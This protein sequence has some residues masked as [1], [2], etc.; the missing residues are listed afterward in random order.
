MHAVQSVFPYTTISNL[1]RVTNN[2]G[3]E[4]VRSS[5]RTL[6]SLGGEHPSVIPSLRSLKFGQRGGRYTS[7]GGWVQPGARDRGSNE[8]FFNFSG[9]YSQRSFEG[10]IASGHHHAEPGSDPREFVTTHE[11]GHLIHYSFGVAQAERISSEMRRIVME[12]AR[13][14]TPAPGSRKGY[15]S[16]ISLY[17]TKNTNELIAEAFAT[18]KRSPELASPTERF[19]YD[20]F[21]K[22]IEEVLNGKAV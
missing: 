14:Y 9:S 13:T 8:L 3:I 18:V 5:L 15:K 11:F 16:E 20:E 6:I 17:A 12:Y 7:V 1:K 2:I 22:L 10:N 21:M 4:A 19:I